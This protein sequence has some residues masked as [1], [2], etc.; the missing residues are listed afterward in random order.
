MNITPQSPRNHQPRPLFVMDVVQWLSDAHKLAKDRSWRPG[1]PQNLNLPV[2]AE[3]RF[4]ALRL[5]S[6][7]TARHECREGIGAMMTRMAAGIPA[8]SRRKHGR[9]SMTR[10]QRRWTLAKAKAQP[11]TSEVLA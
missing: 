3:A 5:V 6:R 10:F 4:A 2:V 11:R 1:V 8:R 7:A 9:T